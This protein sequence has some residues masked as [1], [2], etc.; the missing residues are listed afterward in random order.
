M[1]RL[2]DID[3]LPVVVGKGVNLFR[4]FPGEDNSERLINRTF[5]LLED[6]ADQVYWS[7]YTRVQKA[8]QP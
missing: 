8:A 6:G 1:K 4:S 3:H 7:V 2:T 5:A